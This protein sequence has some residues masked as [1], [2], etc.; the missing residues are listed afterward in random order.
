MKKFL[1]LLLIFVVA[2]GSSACTKVAVVLNADVATSEKYL[3]EVI[4]L[5]NLNYI[6]KDS[7]NH[8]YSIGAE[9]L[10]S[11]IIN[12]VRDKSIAENSITKRL[13]GHY[14]CYL[15]EYDKN[16]TLIKCSDLPS[17]S[18]SLSTFVGLY[19]YQ[20]GYNVYFNHLKYNGFTVISLKEYQLLKQ[21][22]GKNKL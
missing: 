2:V 5:N 17:F 19:Y 8:I 3:D 15:K 18:N 9:G 20:N 6:T 11:S 14:S 1:L 7:K 12:L 22:N 21:G 13:D 4:A 16:N 10:Y